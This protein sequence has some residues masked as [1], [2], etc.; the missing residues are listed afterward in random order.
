MIVHYENSNLIFFT[1]KTH[2]ELRQKIT[3]DYIMWVSS[4]KATVESRTKEARPVSCNVIF[5]SMFHLCLALPC[6]VREP[7]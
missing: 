2:N 1:R 4:V 5:F 7:V 3:A 6:F